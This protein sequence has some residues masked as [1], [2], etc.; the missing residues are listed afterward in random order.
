MHCENANEVLA[1]VEVAGQSR[2]EGA[3]LFLSFQKKVQ[4]GA[5][6]REAAI[7]TTLTLVEAVALS[8]AVTTLCE[9]GG[10]PPPPPPTSGRTPNGKRR[11][12]TVCGLIKQNHYIYNIDVLVNYLSY[13]L[14]RLV[15]ERR[16][17]GGHVGDELEAELAPWERDGERGGGDDARVFVLQR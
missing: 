6:H 16:H 4:E 7:W 12:R 10:V 15:W 5:E 14:T 1:H 8:R 17:V 9:G 3:E 11:L 2:E 13:N